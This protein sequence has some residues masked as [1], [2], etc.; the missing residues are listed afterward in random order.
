MNVPST[1]YTTS[2]EAERKK[3]SEAQNEPSTEK[4]GLKLREDI[5]GVTKQRLTVIYGKA[6]SQPANQFS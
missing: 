4:K 1:E 6:F 5:L 3:L 2:T